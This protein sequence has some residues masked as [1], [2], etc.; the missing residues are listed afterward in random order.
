M[1]LGFALGAT[2]HL[3]AL[4]IP[5]FAE[6]TYPPTYPA[7]RHILFILINCSMTYFMLS[8]PRWLIWPYLVLTAQVCQGHGVRLWH[9]WFQ[10]HR[11]QWIDLGTVCFAL[12]GFLFIC[13]E[14]RAQFRFRN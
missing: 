4:T 14:W 3:A 1:A 7:L 6:A 9:T 5:A 11:V 12:L 10:D 8:R 13:V 2:A